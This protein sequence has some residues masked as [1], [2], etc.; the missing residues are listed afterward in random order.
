[1]HFINTAKICKGMEVTEPLPSEKQIVKHVVGMAWPAVLE[2]L[3]MSL[4]GFFDTLMVGTVSSAAIAAVGLTT[5][6]KFIVLSVFFALNVAV[7]ALVA[8]RKGE[9]NRESANRVLKISLIITFFLTILLSVAMVLLSDPLIRFV[10]SQED[11]HDLAVEYYRIII[12]GIVFTTISFI[13][14]GA[15]RGAGNTRISMITNI[16]SN[17]VNVLF[18][19]LLIGGHF[20]FPALGVRGAAIATVIG[21]ACGCALSIRSLFHKDNF[22]YI[23][24]TKGIVPD[25]ETIKSMGR[26]T[27]SA[28]VEQICL[29]VGFLLFS[30]TVAYLGTKELSAHQIG[31]SMMSMSFSIG[32]GFSVAAVTLIGQSL[33]RRRPE[34]AKIYGTTAQRIGLCLAFVMSLIYILFGRG[35]FSLFTKEEDVLQYAAPIM[36]TLSVMLLFQISQ[37]VQFGCLR[38]AGDTKFTAIIS[39]ISVTCIRPGVSFLLCYPL[40]LGLIGA[41][42]GTGCDQIVR[43]TLSYIRFHK[44]K[45]TQLKL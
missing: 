1:M 33:G 23:R 26:V 11:T 2:S 32:D 25:K 41:W 34:M 15:Q 44:G 30:M 35:I 8:R 28:F 19:Y 9:D 7:S 24:A 3:S 16:T 27:S 6:P 39:L 29:R 37:V 17:V 20:G 14:N 40:G 36:S 4:A 13:I 22:I 5:Q 43:F 18:N 10:G 21:S 38:G 12:I 45:W 31:M 42:I